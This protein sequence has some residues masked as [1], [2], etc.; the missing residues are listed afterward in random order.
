[1]KVSSINN[2]SPEFGAKIVFNNPNYYKT[3]PKL[4]DFSYARNVLDRFEK[5]C[6][7]ASVKITY[8]KSNNID[9]CYFE[10]KNDKTG[11]VVRER[12]KLNDFN[13][14]FDNPLNSFGGSETFYALLETLLKPTYLVHKDFWGEKEFS[15]NISVEDHSVF[16]K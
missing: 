15:K 11:T 14:D 1:M 3:M 13:K 16:G 2:N 6:P 4:N 10:A 7:D 8:H 5:K 9:D 12:L